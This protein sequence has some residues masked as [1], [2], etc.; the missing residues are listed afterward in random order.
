MR[1]FVGVVQCKCL[2][3]YYQYYYCIVFGS[4]SGLPIG[5][6][7]HQFQEEQGPATATSN[8]D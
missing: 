4:L 5:R 3:Y 7:I 2:I 8:G 1:N 6:R